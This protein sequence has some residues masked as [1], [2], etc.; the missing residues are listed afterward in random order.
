MKNLEKQ[1]VLK[2]QFREEDIQRVRNLVTGKY[3]SKINQSVGYKKPDIIRKEG[4]VWEEDGRTW[5]IKK[6]IKQNIT[7][8]DKAKKAHVVPLFC[9]NC[10]KQMKLKN[11]HELYKIHKKC[12]DCVV[13]MEHELQKAG[14]WEEYQQNIKNNEIDN[15][16]R[17]FKDYVKDR[18]SESNNNY[19]SEAGH[20]ETWKGK[21][22]EERVDQHLSEVIEYLESLK[23]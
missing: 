17:D 18:L 1:S 10:K 4:E 3:G 5:T 7:K 9:P 6:G 21:I 11:D 22:D 15:K 20:K 13:E 23:K 12:L 16:I 14:K 19:I 2:K 8:L